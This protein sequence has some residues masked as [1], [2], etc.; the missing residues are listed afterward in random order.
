MH[1]R[2]ATL[3]AGRLFGLLE[4]AQRVGGIA[5]G[6]GAG[7]FVRSSILHSPQTGH[8]LPAPSINRSAPPADPDIHLARVSFHPTD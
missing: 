3:F 4:A 5:A 8:G 6:V 1:R 7:G 2:Q